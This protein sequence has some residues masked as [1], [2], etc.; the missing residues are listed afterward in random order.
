MGNALI[1]AAA[2]VPPTYEPARYRRPGLISS[3]RDDG[4]RTYLVHTATG[5]QAGAFQV[6]CGFYVKPGPLAHRAGAQPVEHWCVGLRVF[7]ADPFGSFGE[8]IS[9]VGVLETVRVRIGAHGFEGAVELALLRHTWLAT[10]RSAHPELVV[11]G[12]QD[13][14]EDAWV[15]PLHQI[16]ITR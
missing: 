9:R 1:A 6:L 11:H 7:A 12:G 16:T 8:G 2:A 10:L 3:W 15:R 5:E 14:W 4:Y 13:R